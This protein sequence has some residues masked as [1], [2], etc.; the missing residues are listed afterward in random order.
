MSL[1]RLVF[2][3]IAHRKLNFVLCLC[4]IAVAAACL[5][6][7]TTL[8]RAHDVRTTQIAA[9]KEAQTKV[10]MDKLE[11]DY[12]KIT[13]K[14]GFNVLI[15]P[16]EQNLADLYA[17]DYA[18]K[19]MPEEYV[20][21]LASSNVATI[22]HLLPMLQEK[23]KWPERERTI[24]LVGTRGE[25]PKAMGGPT[26]AMLQPVQPGSIVLGYELHQ[27]LKL[28]K[29]DKTDLMGRPFTVA[30][31][32]EE[33]GT[34]DDITAWINLRES[35]QLLGKEGQI[36]GI[37]ALECVCAADSLAKV[38]ADIASVL[39]D[40]QVIEFASQTLARAEARQRA[41]I[42]ANQSIEA[43]K[44]QRLRLRNESEGFAA[45]LVPI[46]MI[47]CAVWVA[48]LALA[49]VRERRNEIGILR[50]IG[51]RSR[52]ILAA[53]LGKA[54][55]FGLAGGGIG[56]AAGYGV[57]LAW[58]RPLASASL[59]DMRLLAACMVVSPLL[60]LLGSW[61]PA[62][63]AAQQQPADILREE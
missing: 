49:N 24:I 60:S 16:K 4:S 63:L 33:R 58:S 52:Q 19:Y 8:L 6:A 26:K 47:A 59:F 7:S 29:G 25:V 43:E 46:V 1:W 3:E 12:R 51:L 20:T 48:F 5:T 56:W 17:S 38:R 42:A 22:Q 21:R 14:L 37:L 35:Q 54:F 39:P 28:K 61:I 36:N 27:S 11:D 10:E 32:Y 41:A 15:L 2:R 57:G 50:A 23:I 62:M 31:C 18:T 13:I 30:E 9:T 53:F 44:A 45:L 34:K 40:T 55:L